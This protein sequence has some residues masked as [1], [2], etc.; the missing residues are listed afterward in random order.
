MT[1]NRREMMI[2]KIVKER[3][4]EGSDHYFE[5]ILRYGFEGFDTFSDENLEIEIQE[6]MAGEDFEGSI[7]EFLAKE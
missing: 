6:I 5:D 3:M 2:D 4:I 1:K 7:D